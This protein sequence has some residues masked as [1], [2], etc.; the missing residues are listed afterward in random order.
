MIDGTINLSGLDNQQA[1]IQEAAAFYA[2]FGVPRT[3]YTKEERE[4]FYTILENA[5]LIEK[6]GAIN[7]TN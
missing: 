4:R 6:V 7:G 3:V 2:S 5:G 1:E